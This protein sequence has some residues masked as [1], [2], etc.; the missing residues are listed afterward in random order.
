MLISDNCLPLS[1]WLLK[2]T[3][4][5]KNYAKTAG[6]LRLWNRGVNLSFLEKGVRFDEKQIATQFSSRLRL[7]VRRIDG[8]PGARFSHTPTRTDRHPRRRPQ[9]RLRR[10]PLSRP[11]QIRR[12]AR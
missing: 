4:D 3:I 2:K 7:G 5:R 12:R 10:I 8:S 11:I 9:L 6:M 1:L